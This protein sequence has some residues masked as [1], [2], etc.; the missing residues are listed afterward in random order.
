MPKGEK[1]EKWKMESRMTKSKSQSKSVSGKLLLVLVSAVFMGCNLF[2]YGPAAIFH[3]N[4]AEFTVNFSSILTYYAW[5]FFILIL[6]CLLGGLLFLRKGFERYVSLLFILG[7]LLWLQGNLLVWHYGVLNGTPIDWSR[8]RWQGWID[9]GLWIIFLTSAVIFGRSIVKLVFVTSLVLIVLQGGFLGWEVITEPKSFST[10]YQNTF[11][12]PRDIFRYSPSRNV[13]HILLDSMQTDAF[14]EVVKEN[15]MSAD[16]DGFIFFP[17]NM[18]A[19]GTTAFTLPAIF[20]GK[21]YQNNMDVRSYVRDAV[22]KNAFFS[23]LSKKGYDVSLVPGIEI[24]AKNVSSYYMV[25]KTYGGSENERRLGQAALLMDLVLFRQLPQ[26]FKKLIYN[27]QKWMIQPL[28]VGNYTVGYYYYKS[29]FEDYIEKVNMGSNQP[30]YHFI[31]LLPPHPPFVTLPDCSCAGRVLPPTR[32]NYKEEV[33]CALKLFVKFLHKLKALGIYDSSVIILQAD[34][35]IGFPVKK[36][37]NRFGLST[38][39][40]VV[41]LGTIGRALALLAVKPKNSRGP[42]KTSQAETSVTDIP[43]TVMKAVGLPG[44]LEGPSIFEISPGETRKRI[45]NNQFE[46]Q[47]SVYDVSSWKRIVKTSSAK[48]APCVYQW[49]SVISFGYMGNSKAYQ[50]KGWSLPEDGLTWIDGKSASMKIPLDQVV[51]APVLLKVNLMPFMWP[52][53][54]LRQRVKVIV[55]HREAGSCIITKPGFQEVSF[56][57]SKSV[58]GSS[59]AIFL[60][61]QLP[62]AV[63][64][65][66]LGLSIDQRVLGIAVRSICLMERSP[67]YYGMPIRFGKG[68]NASDYQ[69]KGWSTPETGFTW[70]AG[71]SASLVLPI[72]KTESPLILKALL[73]P[74]LIP[75]KV[76]KQ[77]VYVSVNG[78]KLTAWKVARPNFTE[79][80]ANIPQGLLGN[81]DILRLCFDLP[82]AASPSGLKVS[83]DRRTLGIAFRS[84]C[85][86]KK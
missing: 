40:I 27:N 18:G 45:Y 67:Y 61:F 46:V 31:H 4:T 69:E 25:P 81:T 84:L 9:A 63:S 57:I 22:S 73:R 36:L 85:I 76:N 14:Q 44:N 51:K 42:M 7:I 83:N 74:F 39:D 35:G 78:T 33:K 41:S 12:P 24:P 11:A 49:G 5:P 80:S 47:G 43:A 20:S 6:V 55:N 2:I 60:T 86:V 29:F 26:V 62:D 65:R 1:K 48:S 10:E 75:G 38:K 34:T 23:V 68:G 54:V 52:G 16:L 13:I 37:G 64:P 53:K 82:D 15:K 21:T 59:K 17:E 19:F 58:I 8:F 30:T 50:K 66:T 72:S 77:S 79:W 28:F 71:K 32:D 70:S 56:T 3:G